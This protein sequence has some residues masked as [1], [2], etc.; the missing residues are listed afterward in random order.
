MD[1][2]N[3]SNNIEETNKAK[4][5]NETQET[6]NL[7]FCYTWDDA[8]SDGTFIR[9]EDKIAQEA[10]FKWPIAVTATLYNKYIK[11]KKE[12]DGTGRMWDILNMFRYTIHNQDNKNKSRCDFTVKLGRENVTLWATVEARTPQNPEPVI[13]IMLPSDY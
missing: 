4:E 2:Q 1:N 11:P 9:V 6:D 5:T 12:T 10:G 8:I 7:I 3:N 13:T